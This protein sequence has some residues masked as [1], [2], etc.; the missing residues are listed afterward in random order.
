[1]KSDYSPKEYAMVAALSP[2]WRRLIDSRVSLK[3][4]EVLK[5]IGAQCFIDDT[6]GTAVDS[7][8][9]CLY[10]IDQEYPYRMTKEYD[11]LIQL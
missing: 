3:P 11:S 5:R 2:Y 6:R 7:L 1:M 8:R 4:C 9:R 10:A